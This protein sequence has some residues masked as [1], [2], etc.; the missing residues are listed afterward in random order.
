M[1][2]T[3]KATALSAAMTAS[4]AE[5]PAKAVSPLSEAAQRL[6]SAALAP[7]TIAT[8]RAALASLDSWL[9][10]QGREPNDVAIADY[11]AERHEAGLAPETI[12][13]TVAAVKTAAKLVGHPAPVGEQTFRVLAGIRREGRGRGR[14]QVRGLQWSEA[15]TVAA[16][17]ANS[18]GKLAG[19]RDAAL[20]ALTS[21]CLLRMSEAVAAQVADLETE[22]D[23]SGR[24]T[25][26]RSKT[27]QEGEGAV[28]FVGEST[29]R[30]ITAWRDAGGI[31][32][33]PLFRRIRCNGVVLAEAITD[34]AARA[35]IQARAAEAGIEGRVSGHSLRIGSAQS[36]A[37]AGAGLVEMQVAG[38]WQSPSM[39]GRYARSQLAAR[40]AVARLRHGPGSQGDV[41]CV[42]C[43]RE[44]CDCQTSPRDCA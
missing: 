2:R 13:L 35:I 4:S 12:A 11:L 44:T 26:H 41:L 10:E 3:A 32:D 37:A 19:L 29:M 25:V 7:R 16:V 28:L 9:V 1:P 6:A 43:R 34:R 42:I 38:R 24:L 14:G 20:V 21:D 18:D 17:A 31:H 23:G 5:F 22:A 15:D 8:Y 27:D 36:L 33:G 40:G 30:R 39:P